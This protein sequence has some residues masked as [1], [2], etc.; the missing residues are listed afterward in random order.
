MVLPL[1]YAFSDT[2]AE[3]ENESFGAEYGAFCNDC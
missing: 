1:V 2:S 3:D